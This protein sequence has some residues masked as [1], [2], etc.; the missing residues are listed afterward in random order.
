MAEVI[1]A[2]APMAQAATKRLLWNGLNV[3]SCLPEEA[4][5]VASLSATRDSR[6]GLN[7]VLEKRKPV[8]SGA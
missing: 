3:E 4:R 2:G 5:T 6:E 8:F 1:A 7:A